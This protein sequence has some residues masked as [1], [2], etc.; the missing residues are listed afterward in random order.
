MDVQSVARLIVT[1]LG[2]GVLPHHLVLKLQQ[3]GHELAIFQGSG[4]PLTNSV[5][6]AVL[7]ERSHSAAG[8]ALMEFLK[9]KISLTPARKALA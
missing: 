9:H 2:A 3:E 6:I 5:S 1:G 4:E 7:R 8:S